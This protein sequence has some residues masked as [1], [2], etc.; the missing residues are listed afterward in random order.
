MTWIYLLEQR[1]ITLIDLDIFTIH[2]KRHLL[3]VKRLFEKIYSVWVAI[4][5]LAI[6]SMILLYIRGKKS[7]GLVFRYNFLIGL[8]IL[9]FSI[10]IAT[11]FLD[12]F[13][14]LHQL[15][16]PQQSWILPNDSLLIAWFPLDYFREFAV[17]VESG[18]LVVVFSLLIFGSVPILLI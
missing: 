10:F 7:L 6:S 8:M 16:F 5:T 2:E 9:L 4:S 13:E 15:L 3:D 1:Y 11:D 14:M 18:Y 17:M 12:A